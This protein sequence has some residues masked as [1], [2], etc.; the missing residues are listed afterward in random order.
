MKQIRTSML[1]VGY[2]V[3]LF[4]ST[5]IR[6]WNPA[7]R[8]LGEGQRAIQVPLRHATH[9]S[10]NATAEMA[11]ID[12]APKTDV[13]ATVVLVHDVPHKGGELL[14]LAQDLQ[15]EGYRVLAPDL[16]GFGASS[17]HVPAYDIPTRAAY[18]HDWI[19]ALDLPAVHLVT[20]SHGTPVGI[21]LAS[22]HPSLVKS[23]AMISPIAIQDLHLLR[24]HD[25]NH[26]VYLTQL[27]A[28]WLWEEGIPHFGLFDRARFNQA[29]ARTLEGSCRAA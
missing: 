18:L 1:L 29:Y 14:P 23:I 7:R 28:I 5:H 4:A 21:Y 2:A 3:L 11:Y 8:S 22:H 15:R 26:A 17:L 12:L 16:P 13:S 19:T 20:F 9:S 24:D 10:T 6:S 27:G 25:M